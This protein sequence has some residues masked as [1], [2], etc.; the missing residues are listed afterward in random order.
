MASK[1]DDEKDDDEG[2]S[3]SISK[4]MSDSSATR[5][6]ARSRV[7]QREKREKIDT[8]LREDDKIT[9]RLR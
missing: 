4:L 8:Y 1:Y 9:S 6:A 2:F 5:R 7:S 3:G